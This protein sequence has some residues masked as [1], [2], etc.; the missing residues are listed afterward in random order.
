VGESR[1]QSP[2]LTGENMTMK[3]YTNPLTPKQRLLQ[4]SRQAARAG[5]T[6]DAVIKGLL[7]DY[8]YLTDEMR[9][10]YESEKSAT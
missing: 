5:L 1:A 2:L 4:V 6:F 10:A 9:Q 8:R 3:T 7:P